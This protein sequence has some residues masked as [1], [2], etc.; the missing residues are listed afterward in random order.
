MGLVA[1]FLVGITSIGSGSIIMSM[2]LLVV[3]ASPAVLVGTDI[4]HALLLTTVTG[5]LHTGMG[6][7]DL[8]LVGALVIGSVPGAVLGARLSNSVPKRWLKFA[9]CLLLV[10]SGLRLLQL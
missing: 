5:L 10:V 8:R 7:V 6:N 3:A 9:L 1:G 2:L 4:V